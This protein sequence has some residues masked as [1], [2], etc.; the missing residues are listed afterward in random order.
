MLNWHSQ[1]YEYFTEELKRQYFYTFGQWKPEYGNALG[2]IFFGMR[3]EPDTE[4]PEFQYQK[5]IFTQKPL[6]TVSACII[7]KDRPPQLWRMLENIRDWVDEIIIVDTGSEL[8]G[9]AMFPSFGRNARL[10]LPSSGSLGL[11]FSAFISTMG[12]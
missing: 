4:I 5:H 9:S 2:W 8:R 11:R 6:L 3:P 1:T 10:S 7:S 12:S